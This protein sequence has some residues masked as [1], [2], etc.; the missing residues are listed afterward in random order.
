MEFAVTVQK[1]TAILRATN[2][3]L[4]AN[5]RTKSACNSLQIESESD[6]I[7]SC[8]SVRRV[9]RGRQK[10]RSLCGCTVCA[11]VPTEHTKCNAKTTSVIKLKEYRQVWNPSLQSLDDAVDPSLK[12]VILDIQ[13]G[14]VFFFYK[15][16]VL[17]YMWR[18][19]DNRLDAD[20]NNNTRAHTRVHAHTHAHARARPCTRFYR[21]NNSFQ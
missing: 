21:T 6:S 1:N 3:G 9:E 4:W 2:C 16:S 7:L 15:R 13:E 5:L 11:S 8:A 14:V 19:W 10:Q 17:Y 20:C 18:N 12:A